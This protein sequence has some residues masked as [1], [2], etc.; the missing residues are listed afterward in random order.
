MCMCVYVYLFTWAPAEV[1]R[2]LMDQ[3]IL[4][5]GVWDKCYQAFYFLQNCTGPAD[6]W[7]K[8]AW[9]QTLEVWSRPDYIVLKQVSFLPH[10]V[11][12]IATSGACRDLHIWYPKGG[13][14][15]KEGKKF[16]YIAIKSSGN[17]GLLPQGY[18][19]WESEISLGVSQFSEA[20]HFLI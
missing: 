4:Y 5:T 19:L 20:K 13:S 11:C 17:S 14:V 9:Y 12:F 2:N 10:E 3:L 18:W 6:I 7:N 15:L 8:L 1:W 16:L